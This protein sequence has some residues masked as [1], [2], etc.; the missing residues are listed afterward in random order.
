MKHGIEVFVQCIII[1]F[2]T[3]TSVFFLAASLQNQQAR[4]YHAT[5]VAKI[6]ASAG[7]ETVIQKCIA[8]GREQGYEIVVEDTLLYENVSYYYVKL[9]YRYGIPFTKLIRSVDIEGY[10]R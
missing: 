1:M 8:D 4:N 6:E 9:T 10:A 2:L 3:A 5:T 7:S